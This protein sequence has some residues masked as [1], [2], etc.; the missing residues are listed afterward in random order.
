MREAYI[1]LHLSILIAGF[2]GVFGKLITL[3][4]GMLVWYRMLI[5]S[6]LFYL[7][8]K[9]THRLYA[10]ATRDMIRIGAVGFLLSLHWIA[11]Y[12]SIKASNVS[13][14]VVCFSLT[15]FFTSLFEP[16]IERRRFSLKEVL[17]SLVAV[18]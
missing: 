16:L 2:T 9:L 6:V 18:G 4:E 15:G 7:F 12:G 11:F 8:L 17:F 3:S 13:I 5:T 10:V 14:G 1:K